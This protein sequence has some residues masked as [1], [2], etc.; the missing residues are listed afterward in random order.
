MERKFSPARLRDILIVSAIAFANAGIGQVRIFASRMSCRLASERRCRGL[1]AVIAG[2]A[3]V[4]ATQ[5]CQ[6]RV[7]QM[8][9]TTTE[10][11]TFGGASFGAVGQ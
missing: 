4:G 2:I 5:T 1:L 11:P 10:A 3:M 9:I 8:N 7:T 6:A